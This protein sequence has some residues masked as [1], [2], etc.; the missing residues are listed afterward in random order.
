MHFR[1][2]TGLVCLL[3]GA[4]SPGS[5]LAAWSEARSQHF[6]VYSEGSPKQLQE[7]A[8]KLEKF[9]FLL[10][11]M[12]NVKDEPEN[13]VLVYALDNSRQVQSLAHSANVEG[14]YTTSDRHGYAV[15]SRERAQGPYDIGAEDILF[16]EYAHHFMLH[17]FP[18]AY[19]AWYVEG[20]AEF[21]SE[22]KFP[23]DGSIQFGNAPMARLP[24][25]M[26][27]SLYPL[28]KLFAR[29]TDRLTL[30]DGDRYYGTAWL[31]T[32]YFRYNGKRGEEFDR[33]LKD[34]VAGVPDVTIDNHFAGGLKG[35]EQDLRAYLKA[36]RIMT[37]VM[38]PAQMPKIEVSVYAMDEARAALIMQELRLMGG[39]TKEER[40]PL[41]TAVR[42]GAAKYPQSAYAQTLLAEVELMTERP[43][44]ALAAADKAVALDP[45]LARAHSVRAWVLLDR[46]D[47]SDKPEDWKASLSAI[48]KANRAD[49]EDPVPLVQY[50]RYFMRRG[51]EA[52]PLAY[53]ALMKAYQTLPQSPQYRFML[54]TSLANRKDYK[55]ASAVLAPLAFSPHASGM[56]EGARKLREEFAKAESGGAPV[57]EEVTAR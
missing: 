47:E 3:L 39:M 31:L 26:T 5:A 19:P 20:F 34:I 18:A 33:Y 4:A 46:A 6:I 53:D 9:D 23:S 57:S 42:A 13:P 36:R 41:A 51:G 14:F 28:D 37:T 50:Y 21:Y 48:V 54:A 44:A 11:T 2:I 27:T 35:L 40:E 32:H 12:T 25:L 17:Y 7:F 55:S 49:T 24:T 10:R 38:T 8:E 43:E 45:A 56:R 15:V 1:L 52:P 16:H 22:I 29:D 30:L